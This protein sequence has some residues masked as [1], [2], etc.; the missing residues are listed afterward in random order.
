MAPKPDRV[1]FVDM[2]SPRG[3]VRLNTFYLA[4]L[5]GSGAQLCVDDDLASAYPTMQPV[6]L[7]RPLSDRGF[8]AR[9]ALALKV[10][11]AARKLKATR[12][13]FLSY[14]LATFPLVSNALCWQGIKIFAFEHN[15]ARFG[16]GFGWL[17]KLSCPSAV[18]L[19]YTPYILENYVSRGLQA[20]YIPHP[21]LPSHDAQ[22]D[23]TEWDSIVRQP[24]IQYDLVGLCPSGSA[25]MEEIESVAKLYKNALFVCKSKVKSN[26]PNVTSYKQLSHYGSALK[27]CDFVFIPTN[28]KSRVSGPAFE[29]IAMGKPVMVLDNEFGN[30]LKRM[31]PDNVFFKG[32][33]ILA[34]AGKPCADNH[35]NKIID[36]IRSLIGNDSLL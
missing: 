34:A 5:A 16:G 28:S 19:V 2:M 18:R 21:I 35:N 8:I 3:H 15:T 24:V 14:D 31:F 20:H 13:V 22:F 23:K 27:S 10:V 12:A 26:E 25:S 29:A 4:R 17:H 32:D 1:L 7:G 33:A 6:S 11:S 9:I 36:Q 30:Y